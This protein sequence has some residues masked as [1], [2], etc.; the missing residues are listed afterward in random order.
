M[1]IISNTAVISN[2]AATDQLE[3]LQ[4]L[5]G[6][7]YLSTQVYDEIQNGLE[8]GYLFYSG[9]ERWIH[10]FHEDGWLRLIGVSDEAE[11]GLL[12]QLPVGLHAGEASCLKPGIM[13]ITYTTLI[14]AL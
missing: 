12:H 7:L 11:I 3:L 2:F 13:C 10:P 4:R 6:S 14:K 5:F 1:S 8:E 9:I